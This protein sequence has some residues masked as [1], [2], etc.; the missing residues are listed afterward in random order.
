MHIGTYIATVFKRVVTCPGGD[1]LCNCFRRAAGITCRF[2]LQVAT[3][4][5]IGTDTDRN[6][7]RQRVRIS[8]C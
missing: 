5:A 8:I 1:A 3:E 7:D 2:A 4:Y 6:R